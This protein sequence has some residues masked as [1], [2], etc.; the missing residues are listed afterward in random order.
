MEDTESIDD[1]AEDCMEEDIVSF[2]LDPPPANAATV[3]QQHHHHQQHGH[4]H[5]GSFTT[6]EFRE[7]EKDSKACQN[8]HESLHGDN[9]IVDECNELQ[10]SNGCSNRTDKNI[11]LLEGPT[12]ES[13]PMHGSANMEASASETVTQKHEIIPKKSSLSSQKL[14]IIDSTREKKFVRSVSFPSDDNLVTLAVEPLDPWKNV[15]VTNSTEVISE[16]RKACKQMKT[17]PI[18]S[19][20]KQ[21]Q[22]HPDLSCRIATLCLKGVKLDSKACESLEAIFRRIRFEVI[23]FENCGLEEEGATALLEMIE[24]YQSACRLNVALNPKIGMRGWQTLCRM[25]RK[26]PCLLSLNARR[27]MLTDQTMPMFGRCLKADP[28]LKILHLEGVYL[29]GRHLLILTTALKYNTLLEE[30]YLGD[31]DLQPA[32][33]VSVG[34]MLGANKTLQ[35][36]DLRNNSFRDGGLVHIANGLTDQASFESGGL[37]TLVL[38]NLGLTHEGMFGFCNALAKSKTLRSLNLGQNRVSDLG[39]QKIKPGLIR[40]RSLRKL[41]LMNTKIANEG[42]V[43]L[44]EI[45]ADSISLA[46]IDVREN[47]I[48]IAG[49]MA[50][51]LAMKVNRTLTRIDLDKELRKE[52]GLE[53]VQ[54]SVLADIYGYCHRNKQ[55]M[56]ESFSRES[57]TSEESDSLQ[58]HEFNEKESDDEKTGHESLDEIKNNTELVSSLQTLAAKEPKKDNKG[59]LKAVAHSANYRPSAVA[60]M[61]KNSVMAKPRFTITRIMESIGQASADVANKLAGNVR[62][63]SSSHSRRL[64]SMKG[65]VDSPTHAP[66][67]Q[68]SEVELKSLQRQ[69]NVDSKSVVDDEENSSSPTRVRNKELKD[70]YYRLKEGDPSGEDGSSKD[71]KDS[72]AATTTTTESGGSEKPRLTDNHLEKLPYPGKAKKLNDFVQDES[73][74]NF[75]EEETT[76]DF[77]SNSVHLE[78]SNEF[79]AQEIA[80]GASND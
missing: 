56:R 64:T 29:S 78:G 19:I 61:H 23:D 6:S 52:P 35:L 20:I 33:G 55:A 54:Q 36:L 7:G 47:Y 74:K 50:L 68:K 32:D 12:A 16:Y 67:A 41:G 3:L 70:F 49:L 4:H 45:L 1:V 22:D 25:L 15:I 58:T 73:E 53:T 60:D 26:T 63:D 40:N 21:I 11:N 76:T 75:N 69:Q 71:S 8:I 24:F 27:T 51:S 38:W 80:N 62:L 77:E 31:N 43:A 10:H 30:L 14:N 65:S 79:S 28:Y 9:K 17:K 13:R 42:A 37:A 34:A 39:I 46:R 57:S 44:A 18:V 72:V 48:Q 66:D 59:S 5:H 2:T